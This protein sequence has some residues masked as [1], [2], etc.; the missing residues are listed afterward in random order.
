MQKAEKLAYINEEDRCYG[1][2]GMAISLAAL[3]E[4]D[5]VISFSLDEKEVMVRFSHQYYYPGY[6]NTSPKATWNNLIHN[7]QIT[8]AMAVSNLM[9][10]HLI[11]RKSLR[12]SSDL[13]DALYERILEEGLQTCGLEEDEI[14]TLFDKT[15]RY[16]QR[17]FSNP[18][19]YPL[20]EEF[21][22]IIS[23]RRTLTSSETIAELRALQ[24]I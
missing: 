12:L 22:N 5:Q 19:I 7:F 1:L 20:I 17:I 8:S 10:R 13:I 24:L 16:S 3:D 9:S 23:R 2:A 4:I 21:A 15:M 6:S 18:R 14:R 11:H